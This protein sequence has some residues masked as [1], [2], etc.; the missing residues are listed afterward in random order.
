MNG[1]LAMVKRPTLIPARLTTPG[2]ESEATPNVPSG[3]IR[4]GGLEG[5]ARPFR[6]AGPAR[7]G[8]PL[9]D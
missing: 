1:P 7:E 8:D 2:T 4:R 3:V 9:N 5:S 6:P